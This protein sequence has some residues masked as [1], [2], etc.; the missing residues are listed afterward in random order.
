M[1]V[2]GATAAA[3]Q[4]AGLAANVGVKIAKFVNEAKDIVETNNKI[5][6]QVDNL[7]QT[8]GAVEDVLN[9][10]EAQRGKRPMSL[11][12]IS[13]R[14]KTTKTLKQTS[15]TID[16]LREKIEK[17]GGGDLR[18]GAWKRGWMQLKSEIQN[19]IIIETEKQMDRNLRALQLMLPCVQS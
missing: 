14:E 17:L 19:D 13:A 8:V 16:V 11:D 10:R 7:H 1:D 4:V 6:I 3:F 15:V 12:E 2:L 18:A 5:L 9:R